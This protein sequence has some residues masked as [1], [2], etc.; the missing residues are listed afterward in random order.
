MIGGPGGGIVIIGEE[1]KEKIINKTLGTSV[2]QI[3]R[4]NSDWA[5]LR[6]FRSAP[7]G[8]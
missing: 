6:D 1:G 3:N 7:I 2:K 8:F 4:F 5:C